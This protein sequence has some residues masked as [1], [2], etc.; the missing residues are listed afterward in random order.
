MFEKS[1]FIISSSCY[2]DNNNNFNEIYNKLYKH[3][4]DDNIFKMGC[5]V[6]VKTDYLVRIDSRE[7]K[8]SLSNTKTLWE[9][10]IVKPYGFNPNDDEYP[11]ISVIKNISYT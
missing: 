1:D 9:N 10:N 4:Y 7:I 6:F 11:L 5:E 8:Y 2:I 3:L